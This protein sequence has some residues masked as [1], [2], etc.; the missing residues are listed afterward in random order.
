LLVGRE[1]GISETARGFLGAAFAVL[2]KQHV[3]PTPTFHPFIRV[4]RDFY[5]PDVSGGQDFAAL[6]TALTDGYPERFADPLSSDLPEFANTYIFS[7]LETAVARC[8]R[9]GD[10]SPDSES[11]DRSIEEMLALLRPGDDNVISCRAVSHLRIEG[12]GPLSCG[13][14]EIVPER[15]ERRDELWQ[16]ITDRIP[17]A[18]GSLNREPPFVFNH[19][20]AVLVASRRSEKDS[21]YE[22]GQKTALAI[23][24]FLLSLRLL[25]STTAQSLFELRGTDGLLTRMHPELRE[26]P[27]EGMPGSVR[28]TAMLKPDDVAGLEAISKLVAELEVKREGMVATPFDV[29]LSKFQGS[30]SE[31]REFARLIELATALEA[32]LAGEGES[33]GLTLRLRNR[34]AA[35]LA[36]EGDPA[37]AIFGDVGA[38]YGIRSTLVHGGQLKLKDLTKVVSRISTVE[39]DEG[40]LNRRSFGHVLDRMRDLVRRA[41]LARFCLAVADGEP[42]PISGGERSVDAQLADDAIRQRWRE[43]WRAYLSERGAG[44]AAEPAPAAVD[45]FSSGY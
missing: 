41:I 40:G 2:R 13:E 16:I 32:T 44:V 35:L 9:I 21:P 37:S 14:I 33:A 3:I 24:Q 5:G 25:T 30:Y 22:V 29:A 18:P 1:D 23:D 27:H 15:N 28:R 42:W 11:V 17:A 8:G 4:G 7:L 6:E 36:C 10:F 39:I 26:Y 12:D 31:E 34:A 45:W 43:L 38:L 19:P 20:H